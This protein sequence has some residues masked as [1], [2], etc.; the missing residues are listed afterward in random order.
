MR[1]TQMP[2]GGSTG[3][4]HRSISVAPAPRTYENHSAI[5]IKKILS[6]FEKDDYILAGLIIVLMLEGCDDYILLAA[7][8]YLFFMG[9]K[10]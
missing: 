1:V 5:D 4:V 2:A 8:G 6:R 7:L 10:E 3:S 9:L